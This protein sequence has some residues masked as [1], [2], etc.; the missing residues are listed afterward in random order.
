MDK[1]ST[2]IFLLVSDMKVTGFKAKNQV[3]VSITLCM[4]ID[5][6]ANG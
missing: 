1:V 2:H 5:M 4:E 6:K 3:K